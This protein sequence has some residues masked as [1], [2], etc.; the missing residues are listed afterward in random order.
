ML[1]PLESIYR[2]Y[3]IKR[4]GQHFI[5]E[6]KVKLKPDLN[7]VCPKTEIGILSQSKS[8][9]YLISL[10]KNI[11]RKQGWGFLNCSLLR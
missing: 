6:L 1:P 4:A 8:E 11:M 5:V 2:A 9:I 3:M 7:C 10:K